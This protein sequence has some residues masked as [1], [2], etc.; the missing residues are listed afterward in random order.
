[1]RD[2]SEAF[3]FLSL[4]VA[5]GGTPAGVGTEGWHKTPPPPLYKFISSPQQTQG[6]SFKLLAHDRPFSYGVYVS[7][8]LFA[9][10]RR[11]TPPP[12][13]LERLNL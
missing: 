8:L 5:G 3:L 7:I 10:L 4:Y 11:R 9:S 1:M 6:G 2:G 12:P 13:P